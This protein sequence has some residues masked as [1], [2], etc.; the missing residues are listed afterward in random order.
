MEKIQ[1]VITN[2]DFVK[3]GAFGETQNC[4]LATA[5]KRAVPGAKVAVGVHV[6]IIDNKTYEVTP[7]FGFDEYREHKRLN[8]QG[9]LFAI[10]ITLTKEE[11]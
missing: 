8:A 11:D 9:T 3:G 1:V 2:E 10:P 5:V 6:A 4:P 7:S